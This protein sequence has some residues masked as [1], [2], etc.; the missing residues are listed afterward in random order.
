MD[1]DSETACQKLMRLMESGMFKFNK[2]LMVFYFFFR[3]FHVEVCEY[4][5]FLVYTNKVSV[6]TKLTD[7]TFD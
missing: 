7:S 2:Y 5:I 3:I 1:I 6:H 4:H